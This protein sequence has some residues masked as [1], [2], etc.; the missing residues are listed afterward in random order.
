M[1][2]FEV[3]LPRKL[4]KTTKEKIN[5]INLYNGKKSIYET[6]Y[7]FTETKMN[8]KKEIPVYETAVIDKIV[9]DFDDKGCDAWKECNNL[10]QYLLKDNIKHKVNM[11]GR[12]YHLYIFCD[13][14]R[15]Q[16][17]KSTL[18]NSQMNFVNILNLKCD[19][20]LIGDLARL[21]RIP[22]TYNL[23]AKRFCIPLTKED[24]EKGDSYCK[25]LALK[26]RFINSQSI[27]GEKLLDLKQFDNQNW[28]EEDN[29]MFIETLDIPSSENVE[30]KELP[31][32]IDNILNKKDSGYKERGLVILYFKERGY[33]KQ[34]IYNILKQHL[35]PRKFKHCI[36]EE[37]QLQYLYDIRDDLVF[38]NCESIKKDGFCPKKCD[39]FKN[40]KVYKG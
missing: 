20:Q 25:Q 5:F 27:I 19:S 9:F 14:Y 31:L 35:S 15:P 11:S 34:E 33:S 3:G 8:G 2:I 32:C 7:T 36:V 38:P 13:I 39:Y 28:N 12:G 21:I 6:V 23:K 10:H 1:S 40:Q 22:N 37:R 17:A 16:F 4:C 30:I 24:F 18:F 26:Q 29:L